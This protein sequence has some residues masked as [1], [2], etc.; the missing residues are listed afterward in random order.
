MKK[1]VLYSEQISSETQA[2]DQRLL[3]LVGKQNPTLGYIASSSDP[4]RVWFTQQHRY[5]HAM[6]LPL[7][8]Y[9]ELDVAYEPE[10]MAALF[11]CDAIHLSGGNTFYF[12]HWLRQRNMLAPLRRY[13]AQG[14]VLIGVSAG[15]ILMTPDVST[16]NFCEDAS[17]AELTD[18]AGLDLVDFAFVP[19]WGAY[20]ATLADLEAYSEQQQIT[21]YGCPDGAG[22][23]VE[24][25]QVESFGDVVVVKNDRVS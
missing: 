3:D 22:I 20:K 8:V 9:F 24:D 13:V 21:V 7:S 16:S 15:A 10:K 6:G 5:Y 19:H 14:G 2:I 17:V 25:Q 4:E 1:L 12:L 11:A 23:V 18:Y